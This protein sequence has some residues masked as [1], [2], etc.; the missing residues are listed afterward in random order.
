MKNGDF[1]MKNLRHLDLAKQV[2]FRTGYG[3]FTVKQ[4]PTVYVK[5]Y[6][7][8]CPKTCF[9]QQGPLTSHGG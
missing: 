6:D 9:E 3:P 5:S 2:S 1:T 8:H 7:L 4:Q